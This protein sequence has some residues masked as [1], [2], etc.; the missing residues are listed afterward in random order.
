M[1]FDQK[2][3][4]L[5]IAALVIVLAILLSYAGNRNGGAVPTVSPGEGAMTSAGTAGKPSGAGTT[6]LGK[7]GV[8]AAKPAPRTL[9]APSSIA[10]VS[11]SSGDR[12]IVNRQHVISWSKAAGVTGGIYLIDASTKQTVGWIISNTGSQQTSYAWDTQSVFI[13]RGSALKKTVGSGVYLL[14][15]KLDNSQAGPQSAQFSIIFPEQVENVSRAVSIKNFAF[16]PKD[17]VVNQGD[18]IVFTN[19]DTVV[20]RV[21]LSIFGTYVIDPGAS[22]SFATKSVPPETYEFY[23]EDSPSMRGSFT[24]K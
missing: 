16:D 22:A 24:V 9:P 5:I 21:K 2:K 3:L 1:G 10:F 23:A 19:M 20:H 7:A 14:K 6:P 15:M 13:E 18:T 4:W 11:P 8:P 17:I 12:W